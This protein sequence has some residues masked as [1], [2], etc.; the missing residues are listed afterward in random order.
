MALI[1]RAIGRRELFTD[2]ID[3][4]RMRVLEIG[5][6][7]RPI[8]DASH[9]NAFF[10]DY[11]S[12]DGLIEAHRHNPDVESKDIVEV[13]YVISGREYSNVFPADLRFDAIIAS[14]VVEHVPDLIGWFA[15][16]RNLLNDGGV[17][18]LIVPNARQCFDLRRALTTETDI[19]EAFV[20][21][22]ER[23]SVRQVFDFY[24]LHDRNKSL[25]HTFEQSIDMARRSKDSYVD[26]HCWVFT[27]ERFLK[28]MEN[29]IDRGL[30]SMKIDYVTRTVDEEIDF[31]ASF[32]V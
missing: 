22:R 16:L 14:H 17:L 18:R 9:P 2:G 26:A 30:I 4:S 27:P 19:I 10:A 15:Q 32:R 7:N 12:R 13:D 25:V 11:L 31:F 20:E 29:C 8:F 23:P 24:R 6:L 28:E 5:A 21:Q 3:L 1:N